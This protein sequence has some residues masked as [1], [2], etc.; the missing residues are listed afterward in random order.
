LQELK[1]IYDNNRGSLTK[2]EI[3]LYFWL[4]CEIEKDCR[5]LVDLSKIQKINSR[6]PIN[7]EEY[8]G[9]IFYF[10]LDKN[11]VLKERLLKLPEADR[12]SRLQDLEELALKYPNGVRFSEKGSPDFSP[13]IYVHN[14]FKVEVDIGTLNPDPANGRG[15]SGSQL[16]MK[17]ANRIMK[18]R[19]SGWDQPEDWTW[20]HVENST[21]MQLVPQDIHSFVRHSGGRSTGFSSENEICE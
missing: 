11:P 12:A 1:Y 14:G 21:K 8:A 3:D 18:S 19:D 4:L 15:S 10:Q 5:Q 7:A 9:Q 2:E 20:H 17:E 13:Y 6:Y 16:D